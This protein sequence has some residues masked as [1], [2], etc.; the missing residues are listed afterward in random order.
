MVGDHRRSSGEAGTEPL[1]LGAALRGAW[2]GYRDRLDRELA[3]AGFGTHGAPDG[4][5][6]RLCS[7]T[8]EVT[9]S[10]IGRELGVTRQ[11]ASQIVGGLRDRGF[12][13][14]SPS[15]TDGREKMVRLTAHALDYLR[16]ERAAERRMESRLRRELGAEAFDALQRLLEAVTADS[17]GS[18]TADAAGPGPPGRWPRPSP[19]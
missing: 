19:R 18:R 17:P 14:L 12:V 15:P 2:I 4:R 10:E 1:P 7:A 3:A 5:V 9:I 8:A 16:A 11:A 13:S 6:L